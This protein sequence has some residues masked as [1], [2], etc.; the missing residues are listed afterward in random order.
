MKRASGTHW[1][2][3]A[4]WGAST[5]FAAPAVFAQSSEDELL[6]RIET[7]ESREEIRILLYDYGRLL[8]AGD[9]A[10]WAALFA[11]DGEWVGGFGRVQGRAALQAM[12]EDAMP[13][14]PEDGAPVSFHLLSN[15]QIEVA[16]DNATALT[17]WSYITPDEEGRPS[18]FFSG[19]YDDVL[20]RENGR[21]LF[22]RR[23]AYGDI[24]FDDPLAEGA[25]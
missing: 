16:G 18:F 23:V 1:L 10:G 7:L 9:Y 15:A 5:L 21:W 17:K 24:P 12:L 19:H 22:K 4:V 20:V 14:L 13:P 25:D 11:E 6:A 2:A 8:D 3:C